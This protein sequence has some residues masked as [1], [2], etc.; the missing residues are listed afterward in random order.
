[1][2]TTHELTV[3]VVIES[4]D[5]SARITDMSEVLADLGLQLRENITLYVRPD[6]NNNQGHGTHDV[7]Y[8]VTG[9]ACE[10]THSHSESWSEAATGEEKPLGAADRNLAEIN[11]ERLDKESKSVQDIVRSYHDDDWPGAA[12]AYR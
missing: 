9:V 11:R 2:K 7:A 12:K 3:T 8:I 10:R 6:D 5:E 4:K 1:M